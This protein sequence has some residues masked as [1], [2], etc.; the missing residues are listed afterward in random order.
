MILKSSKI[1]G[2]KMISMNASDDT[3]M[4][5]KDALKR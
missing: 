5:Y 3:E 1:E 2:Y 4:V